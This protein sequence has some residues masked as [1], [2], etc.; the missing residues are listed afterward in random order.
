L[1]EDTGLLS[2]KLLEEA[3]ELADAEDAGEAVHEA[4]DLIYFMLV[5]LA[6]R[7]A[8]LADVQDEL[9]RRN[10]RVNRRPM[11]AKHQQTEA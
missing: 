6:R 1:L 9:A 10:L 11:V 4:A 5:A 7:G 8:T 2:A 3:G